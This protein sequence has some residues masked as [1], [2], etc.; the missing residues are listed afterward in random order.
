MGE[1]RRPRCG[2]AGWGRDFCCAFRGPA[3]NFC[4][5]RFAHDNLRS[6]APLASNDGDSMR[7]IDG[8]PV[9]VGTAYKAAGKDV[10]AR[11]VQMLFA[12]AMNWGPL[13]ALVRDKCQNLPNLSMPN[14]KAGVRILEEA[15]GIR[16]LYAAGTRRA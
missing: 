4:R 14:P 8:S 2:A 10:R 9:N 1:N 11:D 6:L 3:K 15:A 12:D 13:P 7:F 16:G 5:S